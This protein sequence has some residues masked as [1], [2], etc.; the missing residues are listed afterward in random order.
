MKFHVIGATYN[1][2]KY[3]KYC[4]SSCTHVSCT[5]STTNITC[6][7][8]VE[9]PSIFS[10][11]FR[12]RLTRW[13][14]L[15]RFR[16]RGIEKATFAFRI[17]FSFQRLL[18][19]F[20][21]LVKILKSEESKCCFFLFALPLPALV[22]YFFMLTH[23]WTSNTNQCRVTNCDDILTEAK[24]QL[25]FKSQNGS[26]PNFAVQYDVLNFWMPFAEFQMHPESAATH[27]TQSSTTA[28]PAKHS[29]SLVSKRSLSCLKKSV[30]V[31][32][33]SWGHGL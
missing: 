6:T 15:F 31:I 25:L 22:A 17:A 13:D 9:L 8:V 14:Y 27:T 18:I 11:L 5:Y 28:V 21:L 12:R 7:C 23:P 1:R 19:F 16:I 24:T 3:G 33:V 4:N 10:F 2:G 20:V 32:Q 26:T 29:A 30:T